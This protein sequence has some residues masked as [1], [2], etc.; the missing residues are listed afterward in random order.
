MSRE[1]YNLR[2]VIKS[3]KN[4]R[5]IITSLPQGGIPANNTYPEGG[6]INKIELIR[7]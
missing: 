2:Q 7:V 3:G 1:I 5:P 6:F 4:E